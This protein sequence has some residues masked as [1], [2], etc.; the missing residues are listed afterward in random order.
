MFD[1]RITELVARLQADALR[2]MAKVFGHSPQ[3]GLGQGDDQRA[4][5]VL[6]IPGIV[7]TDGEDI[8][9]AALV[10]EALVLAG[11]AH[12]AIGLDLHPMLAYRRQLDAAG[13]AAAQVKAQAGVGADGR[14][15]GA[16]G[17]VGQ[18]RHGDSFGFCPMPRGSESSDRAQLPADPARPQ[19]V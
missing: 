4:A 17:H 16:G 10:D 5:G 7:H 6:L 14:G 8:H 9:I 19:G 18:V 15:S 1:A 2:V 13:R 12:R 3:Q 11:A